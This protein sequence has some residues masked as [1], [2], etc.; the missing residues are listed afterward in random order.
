MTEAGWRLEETDGVRLLRCK[1]LESIPGIAHAFST[2]V[3]SGRADFDL[4]PAEGESP[5]VRTRR[6]RFLSAAGIDAQRPVLLRQMHGATIVAAAETTT[7]AP[8]ADGVIQCAPFQRQGLAPA[9]RTA[10]C[11]AVIAAD[12]HGSAVAALHAGWRGVAAAIGKGAVARFSAVGLNAADLVVALGPSILGCCYEVGS[13]VVDSL[14]GA[15]GP[16][17]AFVGRAPSG[18][19]TVDLHRAL[20]AQFVAAG[21]PPG[22]VQS[23]PFC[24]RCRNELFFSFR[25][26]GAA[27]GRLMAA[28]GPGAGP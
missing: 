4:G 18:R 12:R 21:V 15:C 7:G 10:D 2:R 19:A 24:T 17:D 1:A 3:A 14:V 9:V 23:A 20:R 22:S 13:E 25:A 5:E 11:V 28:V 16:A 8:A 26:E 6:K 27:A